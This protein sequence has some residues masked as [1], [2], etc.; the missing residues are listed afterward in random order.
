LAERIQT[1]DTTEIDTVAQLNLVEAYKK[2][3]ASQI[4]WNYSN[5]DL[6]DTSKYVIIS[7]DTL[8]KIFADTNYPGYTSVLD[9]NEAPSSGWFSLAYRYPGSDGYW[10]FSR[11]GFN[12]DS[13]KA[14]VYYEHYYSNLGSDYIL[15]GLTKSNN[16]W[17]EYKYYYFAESKKRI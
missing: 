9:S 14:L 5:F 17:V 10:K 2:A 3:N 11:I 13:T 15:V 1:F 7:D 6:S 12:L 4:P 16:T 8:D